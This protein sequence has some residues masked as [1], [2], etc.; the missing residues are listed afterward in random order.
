MASPS[1]ARAH[2]E[3]AGRFEQA[4][5]V[6]RAL[7]AYGAAIQSSTTSDEEASAHLGSARVLRSRAEWDE[8]IQSAR[9]AAALADAAGNDDLAAE[10]MNAEMGV[11][12]LRGELSDAEA[13]G[14]RALSRARSSRTR[15]MLLANLGVVAFRQ[16]DFTAADQ[17]FDSGISALRDARHDF[18]LAA[19]LV[20]A[21]QAAREAG[22]PSRA[23]E[24][25][26][27]AVALCRRVNALDVLGN[28]VQNQ[29]AALLDL[30]RLDQAEELLTEALGHFT[31][32]GY[33]LRQAECL[34]ILGGI[35]ERRPNDRDTARRCY[36]RARALAEAGG[37][38][39]LMDRLGARLTAVGA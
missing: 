32:A 24:L 34:E 38:R 13:V 14:K 7:E 17:Y 36:S 37:D 2:L 30:G 27:E 3:R 10:A 26:A 6:A 18:G 23:L 21:S 12:E 19:M 33:V 25:S 29:A 1:A 28:A 35:A 20:N 8:A 4:G 31:S 15:G 16:R 5:A 11:H 39:L 22:D 9:R